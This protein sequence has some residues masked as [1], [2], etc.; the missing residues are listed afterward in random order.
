MTDEIASYIV[1]VHGRGA[2]KTCL[3]KGTL[4]QVTERAEA[5]LLAG[6]EV[7]VYSLKAETCGRPAYLPE[8]LTV[9]QQ[10]FNMWDAEDEFKDLTSSIIN[11]LDEHTEGMARRYLEQCIAQLGEEMRKLTPGEAAEHNANTPSFPTSET[12]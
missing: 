7:H 12:S 5:C 10:E 9:L 4:V 1:V 8:G 3:A 2:L 11:H 6:F